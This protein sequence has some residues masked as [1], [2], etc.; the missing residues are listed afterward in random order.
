MLAMVNAN[1]SRV[2][3]LNSY[4]SLAY[5]PFKVT[6]DI[7]IYIF[8]YI[9]IYI[10]IHI[11]Y[12]YIY[13]YILYI[14]IIYMYI[15]Y[16]Y[17][18]VYVSY[19]YPP[20]PDSS[21]G[22]AS[23]DQ[24][25]AFMWQKQHH[26]CFTAMGKNVNVSGVCVSVCVWVCVWVW[27]WGCVCVC[28]CCICVCVCMCDPASAGAAPATVAPVPATRPVW[29]TTPAASVWWEGG[30]RPIPLGP[31]STWFLKSNV[32]NRIKKCLHLRKHNFYTYFER[33][34]SPKTDIPIRS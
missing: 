22:S 15:L 24:G 33:P 29:L 19:I 26:P 27:V 8:N 13:I 20:T 2:I 18:C 21:R 30:I 28:A 4:I 10:Y 31:D 25:L 11:I 16:I 9:Y 5:N 12:I 1:R 7:Y 3:A 23:E 34:T 14:Y 6:Y 32:E 17:I